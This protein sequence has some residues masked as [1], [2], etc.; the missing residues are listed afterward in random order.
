MSSL[1]YLKNSEMRCPNC[2]YEEASVIEG[3]HHETTEQFHMAILRLSSG[4]KGVG[5]LVTDLVW[6]EE[7]FYLSPSG[8]IHRDALRQLLLARLG[9]SFPRKENPARFFH[10]RGVLKVS[11]HLLELGPDGFQGRLRHEEMPSLKDCLIFCHVAF[12][13]LK[14]YYFHVSKGSPFS[15]R[16]K[17]TR[18]PLM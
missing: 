3:I 17:G 13:S 12:P 8:G 7:G 6:V 1:L 14:N 4:G 11:H 5:Q 18:A 16:G 2:D 10:Q 15:S 9:G